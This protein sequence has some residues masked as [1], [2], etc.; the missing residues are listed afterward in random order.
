MIESLTL[1]EDNNMLLCSQFDD[2]LYF[3]M[4]LMNN[5]IAVILPFYHCQQLFLGPEDF[6]ALLVSSSNNEVGI[7][8]KDYLTILPLNSKSSIMTSLSK[9]YFVGV[10]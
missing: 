5:S 3:T 4:N 7:L 6:S 8:R 9:S 10:Y 1:D 2:S